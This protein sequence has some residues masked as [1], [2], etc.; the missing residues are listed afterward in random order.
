MISCIAALVVVVFGLTAVQNSFH[1]KHTLPTGISSPPIMSTLILDAGHGGEDGGAVSLSGTAESSINLAIALKLDDL[2]GF[3]GAPH[4]LLRRED[5]S[6]HDPDASTLREKKVSDL[7]NRVAA[8]NAA[9]NATLLSIHQNSYPN[10]KYH[11]AQV[12]F[13][14]TDGSQALA[15]HIQAALRSALQP[16]NSRECKQI[17]STVYLMNHIHCPGV[18]VECGFLTNQLEE[19]MLRE[20]IY[21]RK[22]AAVLTSAWLTS[23]PGFPQVEQ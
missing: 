5:I 17:P 9:Q 3:Y 15:Q 23:Q 21:Q 20:T 10:G 16:E 6:L 7:H 14:P 12:F 4:I 19:A 8:V 2:L 13:A 18:L 1:W 11:G 22:L